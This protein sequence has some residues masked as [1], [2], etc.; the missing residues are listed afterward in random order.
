MTYNM[1]YNA[2]TDAELR[3]KLNYHNE[4]IVRMADDIEDM[5]DQLDEL[6]ASIEIRNEFIVEHDK[7]KAAIRV[8][9]RRRARSVESPPWDDEGP[10]DRLEEVSTDGC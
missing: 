5:Q 4:R 10:W 9:R 6:T 8:E 3:T 2:F 7:C 1:K